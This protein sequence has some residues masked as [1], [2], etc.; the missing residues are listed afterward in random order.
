MC[1]CGGGGKCSCRSRRD[2]ARARLYGVKTGRQKER[3]GERENGRKR[4]KWRK[5]I[6]GSFNKRGRVR[7]SC[8]E[9]GGVEWREG[10]STRARDGDWS[11]SGCLNSAE[12]LRAFCMFAFVMIER[13]LAPCMLL[14][15]ELRLQMQGSLSCVPLI[16][17]FNVHLL[18]SIEPSR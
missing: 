7:G 9:E 18:S 8:T 15:H 3:A 5:R 1:V 10:G 2:S 16:T 6:S 17:S 13:W 14:I 12:M 11:R 4:M